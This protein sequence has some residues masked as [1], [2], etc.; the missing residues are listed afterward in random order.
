MKKISITIAT[1]GLLIDLCHAAGLTVYQNTFDSPSDLNGFTIHHP[2]YSFFNPPSLSSAVIESGQLKIT[3]GYF[4][5]NG[6]ENPPLLTGAS[7]LIRNTSSFGNGYN[8]ILSQNPSTVSWSLNL[9]NQDDTYNNDFTVILSSTKSN[10][11]DIG[12]HGYALRGGGMVGNKMVLWRFDF[13][14]GGGGA[15]VLTIPDNL[16]LGNLP[17]RGSF[18]VSYNPTNSLWSLFGNIGNSYVDPETVQTLMA[19]GVDAT[20]THV[21]A[22]YMGLSGAGSGIN[23]FDNLKV[24]LVPEPTCLTLVLAGLS[25]RIIGRRNR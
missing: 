20:Y 25:L 3:S 11:Y 15:E 21:D 19:S 16:G 22:I 8:S 2:D 14:L 12:A 17:Q 18:K 7:T 24:T 10:P 23:F 5:P 9:A 4:F 13:G 1:V 6:P